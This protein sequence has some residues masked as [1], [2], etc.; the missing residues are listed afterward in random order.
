MVCVDPFL[1]FDDGSF[2]LQLPETSKKSLEQIA[3]VFGDNLVEEEVKLQRQLGEEV[4]SQS[5]AT[6]EKVGV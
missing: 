3:A 4:F 5:E 6:A 2:T 1:Q